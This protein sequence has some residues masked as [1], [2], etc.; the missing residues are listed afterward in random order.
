MWVCRCTVKVWHVLKSTACKCI[1]GNVQIMS[2]CVCVC[3]FVRVCLCAFPGGGKRG[4]CA[5]RGPESGVKETGRKW[6]TS[7][8]PLLS[9]MET[10]T[11]MHTPTHTHIACCCCDYDKKV[12]H[13]IWDIGWKPLCLENRKR[14]QREGEENTEERG[15][16]WELWRKEKSEKFERKHPKKLCLS[17]NK[18]PFFY[19]AH[20]LTLSHILHGFLSIR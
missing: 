10:W 1:S 9:S 3:M 17:I 4:Q 11:H 15:E 12:M 7:T 8:L 14:V 2:M 18:W 13:R 6:Q 20:M 19:L 5:A 16:V